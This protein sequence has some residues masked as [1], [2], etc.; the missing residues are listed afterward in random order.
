[1][2]V[3]Y[4]TY[5]TYLLVKPSAMHIDNEVVPEIGWTTWFNMTFSFSLDVGF[6][7]LFLRESFIFLVVFR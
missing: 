4:K 3:T 7:F 5:A 1:M 6:H 2:K